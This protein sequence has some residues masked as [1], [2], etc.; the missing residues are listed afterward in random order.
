MKKMGDLKPCKYV[1]VL[2]VCPQSVV[3]VCYGPLH[4][5]QHSSFFA[6]TFLYFFFSRAISQPVPVEDT[7]FFFL[8][9]SRNLNIHT[10]YTSPIAVNCI[11]LF[12]TLPCMY[13]T[14]Q[15]VWPCPDHLHG[16]RLVAVT[17]SLYLKHGMT[18]RPSDDSSIGR[19][20]PRRFVPRMIRP[21]DDASHGRCVP[22]TMSHWPKCPEDSQQIN[23]EIG[24]PQEPC[25]PTRETKALH[26]VPN[27]WTS[28]SMPCLKSLQSRGRILG[29]NWTKVL[30]VILHAIHCHLY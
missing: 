28:S 22:W 20:V 30:R 2:C 17:A 24:F 12:S 11:H 3:S 14:V 18:I 1:R 15:Y 21:L 6:Y 27:I 26:T 19:C 29:R 10:Q 25:G 5:I 4:N 23:A 9:D 16:I 13:I 8:H 7:W